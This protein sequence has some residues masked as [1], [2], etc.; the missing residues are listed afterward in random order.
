M[1]WSARSYDK[2]LIEKIWVLFETW[3]WTQFSN[4]NDLNDVEIYIP[5]IW[6]SLTFM[7]VQNLCRSL[8]LRIN[9]TIRSKRYITKYWGKV[10]FCYS[11][12]AEE[13]YFL[14]IKLWRPPFFFYK[15]QAAGC[16]LHVSGLCNGIIINNSGNHTCVLV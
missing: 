4:I 5:V 2:D 1:C 11:V 13:S 14:K 3:T 10:W 15:L 9:K 8:F 12:T 7:Y 6:N 16:K